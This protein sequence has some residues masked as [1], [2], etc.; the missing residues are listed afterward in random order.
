MIHEVDTDDVDPNDPESMLAATLT[1]TIKGY[2]E[3]AGKPVNPTSF[4]FA[5]HSDES[6]G[7]MTMEESMKGLIPLYP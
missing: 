7:E 5:E 4:L 2:T 1:Q 3:N 6:I